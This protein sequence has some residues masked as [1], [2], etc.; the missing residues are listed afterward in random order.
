MGFPLILSA[1]YVHLQ[2]LNAEKVYTIGFS[3]G[4]FASILFGHYLRADL[5][6]S[7][8]P[9]T[10]AFSAF[11]NNYRTL[12]NFKFN[13][14]MLSISDLALVQKVS[15]GFACKTVVS[16]CEDS[17]ININQIERL[18]LNDENLIINKYPCNTHNLF[19]HLNIV[20]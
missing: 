20:T 13:L 6:F 15:G 1:L 3:A 17:V 18:H 5:A 4:G 11:T 16:Y 14:S 12:M 19:N 8:Y 2:K 9:Q 10:L 7:Y